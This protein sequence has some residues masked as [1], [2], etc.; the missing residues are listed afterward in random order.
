MFH[1]PRCTAP[2]PQSAAHPPNTFTFSLSSELL[3][4]GEST[5]DGGEGKKC[6]NRMVGGGTSQLAS[7]GWDGQRETESGGG[8]SG[9][10]STF[11][12]APG[13]GWL[14]VLTLLPNFCVYRNQ[15]APLKKL[16]RLLLVLRDLCV[17]VL[18][19]VCWLCLWSLW[20]GNGTFAAARTR[21]QI[22]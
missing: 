18:T 17:F 9:Q 8:G 21:T 15:V 1:F 16:D 2:Y 11:S 10:A 7:V 19:P 12:R 4:C 5:R 22:A 14:C 13:E 3:P 6:R 20:I